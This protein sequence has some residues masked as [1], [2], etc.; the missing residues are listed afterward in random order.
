MHT[1]DENTCVLHSIT[2]LLSILRSKSGLVQ[3]FVY[4]N[5][6]DDLFFFGK[7]KDF[8]LV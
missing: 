7:V 8:C 5:T 2:L 1:Q 6:C 3:G 4:K